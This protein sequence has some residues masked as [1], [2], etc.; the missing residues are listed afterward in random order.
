MSDITFDDMGHMLVAE[1]SM[2]YD[3]HTSRVLEY[4]LNTTTGAWVQDPKNLYIGASIAPATAA[5]VN[6]SAGGVDLACDGKIWATGD[7]MRL[8]PSTPE[9]YAYGLT[10]M[11]GR[12]TL[13]RPSLPLIISSITIHRISPS[14]IRP[15]LATLSLT[16]SAAS[17]R[18]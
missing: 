2:P 13:W 11:R 17:A 12:E 14:T 10:Q 18:W 16:G 9:Q 8:L 5:A 6:S 15:K 4:Q 3:A 1:R 7:A